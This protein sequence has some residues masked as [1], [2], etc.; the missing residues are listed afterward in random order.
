MK[1]WEVLDTVPVPGA[2]Q[3]MELCRRGDELIIRVDGRALMSTRMVASEEALA[4][5]AYAR[6]ST[7]S[8]PQVLIGG[9]G[10]GFTAA[11]TLRC[12]PPDGRVLVLELVPAVVRWNRDVLGAAAGHPLADPRLEVREG[13]VVDE[14][15]QSKASWDAILLDVDNGPAGLSTPSNNWLYKAAGLRALH[16]ALKPKGV[17]SIWSAHEAP[18]FPQRMESAGFEVESKRVRGRPGNKGPRHMIYL[19]R[20]LERSRRNARRRR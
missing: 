11:A 6:L 13:D 18:G 12:S 15:R 16:W 9:L 4:E 10:M 20:R 2:S 3:V 5:L 19:G 14:V 8:S 1:P 17:L 7:E